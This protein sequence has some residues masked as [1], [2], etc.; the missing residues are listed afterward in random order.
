MKITIHRG[1]NQIGGS[2]IEIASDTTKIILD[3]GAELDED[4][5]VAP[6]I[7]GLFSGRASYHAVFISHYHGDHLGL[8][9][10][11]LPGIPVY[12]GKG[13]ASVTNASRRYLNKPEYRFADYYEAGKTINIGDMQITPYLCDHSAFDA[14]MF[15]IACG[16]KAVIYSGDFRAN[17]RKS[18][19]RL[20]NQLPHA[21]A[22]IIEGTTLS[23]VFAVPKTEADLENLAV[24]AMADTESPVFMLQA[25]T[26]IDRLVTTFKAARRSNR[27]LI[28][29]LYMAEVA[30]AAGENIPNARTFSGV[31]VFI[32]NGWNGRHELLDSKYHNAKIGR[33]GIAKERFVMCVR[34]SMQS[35]LEKLSEEISFDGGILFYSM[36]DGYKE[37]EDIVAFL[38]F[39]KEKGVRIIDL[40]TSGHADA[41]TIQALIDDV[42]PTYI[43]PVHTENAE[44]FK[45]C[46]GHIVISQKEFSL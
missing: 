23:R 45:T 33:S 43:M 13:A 30:S 36:W 37:K 29:D 32:T 14:Y 22:L 20:L 38:Q 18:F 2:I 7:D 3:A 10:Q 6:Q 17:G 9:D 4:I 39:M 24:V 41:K 12:I 46:E 31:R 19:S 35:Y 42:N 26:N 25:A 28:Q 21:D 40:H 11:V 27:I 34:L 16:G 8:C 44:W 5:P 1:Q 15:R